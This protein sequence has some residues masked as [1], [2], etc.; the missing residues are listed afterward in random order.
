MKASSKN[1]KR[2]GAT[3]VM[4]LL[5]LVVVFIFVAIAIDIGRVQLAQL[6]MQIAADF[7]SRAGVEAMGRGV[8]DPEVPGSVETAIRDEVAMLVGLNQVFGQSTQFDSQNDIVFG[9]ATAVGQKLSFSPSSNGGLDSQTDAIRVRPDINQ[10]PLF[11]GKFLGRDS[12]ALRTSAASKIKD[13]DIV[14]VLDKSTSMLTRDAGLIDIGDYNSNLRQLEEAIY[15][16]GDYY[17]PNNNQNSWWG[18]EFVYVDTSLDLTRIQA[19]K[20]AVLKFREQIDETQ[21]NEQLALCCYAKFANIPANAPAAPGTV[22]I[23]SGLSSNVFTAIVK[24]GITLNDASSPY[25]Q[26]I[27]ERNAAELEDNSNGYDNFDFNYLRMRWAQ[28]TNIAD[29]IERGAEVLFSSGHRSYAAPILIVLT[30][31][32]H[33]QSGT[34]TG[35]A[36]S[37]VSAHPEVRIYT[38]TFGS[39]ADQ[40]TMASVATIGGGIHHHAADVNELTQV[41]ED[42]AANAGVVLFE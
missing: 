3:M 26:H 11:F 18:T 9:T 27:T 30:D 31:G 29:G 32:M 25:G 8:G 16:P 14:L 38:V 5:L 21:A 22:D 1:S 41:F 20:L 2:R 34:P 13:R 6:K 28:S 35:S 19:L 37:V 24:D 36:S 4:M 42:L 39:G 23:I 10:F 15:G 40:T 33:N 12:L 7:S 17:H